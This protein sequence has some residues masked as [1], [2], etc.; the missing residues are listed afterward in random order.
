MYKQRQNYEGVVSLLLGTLGF[1]RTHVTIKL[2]NVFFI[3][4]LCAFLLTKMVND[5]QM[6][7]KCI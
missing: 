7:G 5:V 6:P 3:N 2:K 4:F 1:G